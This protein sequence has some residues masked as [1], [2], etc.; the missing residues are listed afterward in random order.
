MSNKIS[1]TKILPILF[2]L[3]NIDCFAQQ[4]EPVDLVNP[5]I[6]TSECRFDFFASAVVPMGMVMLSPDTKHG[7]LWGCGYQ[8]KEGYIFDFSHVHNAQT[9]GVPVMPV[10]GA[11]KGHLG[12]QASKSAFSH[13]KEVVKMGYHKVY[14]E[15]YGITAEL[16]ATCRVGMH[17]YTFPETE[18]AHV[19]FDI[20]AAIGPTKMDYA[21]VR[22][23]SPTEIEG[24][25]IQTPTLRRPK[26]TLVHFVAQVNKPFDGFAGWKNSVLIEAENRIIEGK[27]SGAYLTF[28]NLKAGESIL[29]KVAISNVSIGNA[30]LNMAAEL[31][32][33]N[34]E[35]VVNE[36]RTAWNDYLG[37][38]RIEGGSHEQQVKFYT[39]LMHVGIGK[40]VANDVNGDYIDN[41]STLPIIRQLP[42]SNGKPEHAFLEADGLWGAQWNL[43]ILWSL[44]YSEYGNWMAETFLDYYRNVGTLSRGSWGGNYTYVMVGDH[45][46]PLLAA[47]MS[48]G[49]ATFDKELAYAGSRKNAFPG[50]IRDRAGYEFGQNPSGGGID[51]YIEYGYVP[52]EIKDR[53][54]G[55]HRG[56]TSMTLEYAYQ[57][58]CI[59][60]MAKQLNKQS[61]VD[62]FMKRSEYWRNVFDP[63]SGWARPRLKSGEWLE[64]FTPVT[65]GNAFSAAGFIE[66]SSATYTF[67]VPQNI[68]GLIESMGGNEKFAEILDGNFEKAKPYRFVTPHGQHGKGWVDYENQPS[69]EI[70]HL[71][72]YAGMPW[73]TQ[74]WVRQVKDITFGGITPQDGYNGDEDQGQ[75][76]ALGVLMAIG[77]FDVHGLVG[78]YPMLEITSPVFD[79]ITI[80]FPSVENLDKHNTF[81]IIAKRKTAE[82]IYIQKVKLNG[83]THNYFRFPMTDFLKGGTL[84]IELGAKPSK[85]WGINDPDK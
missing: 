33:W 64:P 44:V 40:H 56:G 10:T 75:M 47:L 81:E 55:F 85:E 80:S 73:K 13:E 23:T 30:R 59:A 65:E 41:T 12:L 25:S 52:V 2:C 28:R 1:I 49:R 69:C 39:D 74:Y 58:W 60:H 46:T 79:R 22:Q 51:W 6:N 82:D 19:L 18:E 26:P 7:D 35:Q 15:Y 72:S 66:G 62:L 68:N 83:E 84:E 34:F 21:Y 50:G 8:W 36:A 53:G 67:Y 54:A 29:L 43:N 71:F 57:D 20:G 4:P 77:L 3:F 17:R 27:E 37:R 31:P 45:A 76:G 5:L 32:H 16:T 78:E 9:A 38:F 11:C 14:L 24:Y 61:D 63:T 42:I 48:T 70:A